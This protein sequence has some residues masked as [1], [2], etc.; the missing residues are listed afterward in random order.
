MIFYFRLIAQP[1]SSKQLCFRI[2]SGIATQETPDEKALLGKIRNK[3][4]DSL[5]N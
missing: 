4:Q 2:S 1:P 5:I 3:D